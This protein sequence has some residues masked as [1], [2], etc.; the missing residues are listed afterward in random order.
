MG[1]AETQGPAATVPR[2][3]TLLGI[4]RVTPRHTALPEARLVTHKNGGMME[5]KSLLILMLTISLCFPVFAFSGMTLEHY[6]ALQGEG[7]VISQTQ[8]DVIV[9]V[10]NK[11]VNRD[12]T[13]G[14]PPIVELNIEECLRGNLKP[15]ICTSVWQPFPHDV[16]WVGDDTEELIKAWAARPLKGP[17]EKTKMILVGNFDKEKNRFMVSALGRFEYSEARKKWALENIQR[18]VKEQFK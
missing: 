2:R 5:K 1:P 14:N 10:I 16:D 7:A 17:D 6:L 11:V 4:S 9:A 12:T 15:G 8:W 18:Q 13:N 3:I